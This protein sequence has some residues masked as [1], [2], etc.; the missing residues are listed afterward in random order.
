MRI[1]AATNALGG[2]LTEAQ[3]AMARLR[4]LTPALRVSNLNEVF[5]LRRPEDLAKFA[6]GL[7]RAGL[8]E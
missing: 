2:Q 5:P 6:E 3:E 4:R 8:P 7:R 1:L